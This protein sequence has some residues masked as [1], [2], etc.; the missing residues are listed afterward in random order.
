VEEPG[1]VHSRPLEGLEG[2][3]A[4]NNAMQ[5]NPYVG[6]R[7]FETKEKDFFFGREREAL[8]LLSLVIS[9]RLVLFYA[10]SGAGK[11]SLINTRLIPGLIEQEEYKVLPVGRLLGES[12]QGNESNNIYTYNLITSLIKQKLNETLVSKL[13]LPEFLAG[14]DHDDKVGYFYNETLSQQSSESDD[15]S[16]WKYVLIIDQFEELFTTHQEEWSKREDFFKQLARAMDD[17]PNLWIVLVLREDYIAMLDPY[18]HLVPGRF[19]GRYYM[20]RLGHHAA[21]EAVQGPAAKL[22]RPFADGVA[23]KLVNDLSS[24]KVRKPDSTLET[25][26]GQYVEPVQ[27]QVV[28]SSLWEKLPDVTQITQEDL[29]KY[30]G[31]VNQALG[32]YYEER[33]KAVADGDVAERNGVKERAIRDWFGR[34]L[35]T[36]DGI[37]NMV[38][39]ERDGESG[40]LSDDVVQE[41]VKR[42]D[43]VRAEKRGGATFYELTHDRLVEPILENN[44]EWFSSHSSLVQQQTALWIQQGRS[45][46]LLLRGGDLRKA[47]KEA[48]IL[49]LTRDERAFLEASQR[50]GRNRSI[51]WISTGIAVIAMAIL[52]YTALQASIEA[53]RQ[54]KIARAEQ[55]SAIAITEKDQNFEQSLIFGAQALQ[56]IENNRTRNA[57]LSLL[58]APSGAILTFKTDHTAE[59]NDILVSSDGK[60]LASGGFDN[61]IIFWDISSPQN[62]NKLSSIHDISVWKLAISRNN[63]ILAAAGF[64]NHINLYDISN[65]QN[66]LKIS[67]ISS[68]RG[69][70]FSVAFSQNDKMLAS[71]SWDGDVIL[72]DISNPQSLKEL[73]RIQASDRLLL[74]LAFSPDNTILATTSDDK[75]IVLWDISNPSQPNELSNLLGHDSG[76]RS[77]IFNKSGTLLASG[78]YD[79]TI[80]LWDVYNPTQP[81]QISRLYGYNGSILAITMTSDEK[82]LAAGDTS[83]DI[84]LWDISDVGN[85]KEIRRLYGHSRVITGLA[86]SQDGNYLFS[87]SADHLIGIWDINNPNPPSSTKIIINPSGDSFGRLAISTDNKILAVAGYQEVQLWSLEIPNSPKLVQI[88]SGHDTWV[89]SVAFSQQ[90]NFLASAG[91]GE[92]IIWSILDLGDVRRVATITDSS[93]W[94]DGVVFSPDGKILISVNQTGDTNVILWDMSNPSRPRIIDK[95]EYHTNSVLDVAFSPDNKTFATSGSAEWDIALWETNGK[96][97]RKLAILTGHTNWV[98]TVRFSPDGTVLVSGDGSGNIILWDISNNK[99]PKQLSNLVGHSDG[100]TN[101]AFSSNGKTL[102]SAGHDGKV[103]LWDVSVPTVPE[104]IGVL[105]GHS[106][107]VNGVVFLSG[108][109]LLISSSWDKTMVLWDLDP[110]SWLKKACQIAGRNFTQAEW[111]QYFPDEEYQKTC[112]QWPLESE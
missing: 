81:Q 27:L 79:G 8:D 110:Q 80:I 68:H 13:T 99:D 103:I 47:K 72:W 88:L 44:K 60:V 34:K 52:S 82:T 19:R 20:Q 3:T 95:P 70:I 28:C 104:K 25:Q 51:V 105:D 50:S 30:V 66:P 94:V 97:A 91:Q 101:F 42:G 15:D 12:N 49:E 74:D 41:F 112:Q 24:I 55:L 5:A 100:I 96:T 23:E 108:G 64:D 107:T 6:A 56:I 43:L 84:T 109:K 45:N 106:D 102:A 78:S 86:I 62:P 4:M 93:E 16:A 87:A 36:V 35:I 2:S 69:R 98:N 73:G 83:G 53:R 1:T 71:L 32:N 14:L 37:R 10:Q 31:D 26:A 46:G 85:P 7:T 89:D 33:V 11:S 76:I 39:Q 75:N 48:E 38:A 58:Q 40:G 77:V 90:G 92:I 63:K 22:D 17:F 111:Q 67:E 65:P 29:D 18:A 9:E 54:E 61:T 57:M 21:S 59:V